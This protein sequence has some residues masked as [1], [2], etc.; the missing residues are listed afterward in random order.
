MPTVAKRAYQRAQSARPNTV[1][2]LMIA[3][4]RNVW[5]AGVIDVSAHVGPVSTHRP[6]APPDHS[7]STVRLISSGV[8]SGYAGGQEPI[9]R[10][11][12]SVE[13]SNHLRESLPAGE[14]SGRDGEQ[15]VCTGRDLLGQSTDGAEHLMHVEPS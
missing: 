3:P 2:P 7:W 15:L 10:P 13:R 14:L 6:E 5:A 4:G 8:A 1:G 11:Y 9:A 12:R